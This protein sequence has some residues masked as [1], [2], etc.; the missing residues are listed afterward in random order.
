MQFTARKTD[1]LATLGR[2]LGAVDKR[3]ALPV[4]SH[5]LMTVFLRGAVDF[6]ACDLDIFAAS[7]CPATVPGAG[8]A[9][10]V[11]AERLRGA[12]QAIP[13]PEI[14]F[15]LE[16]DLQLAVQSGEFRLVLSCLPGDEFV[17]QT[18]ASGGA[19]A[20]FRPEVLPRLVKEVSHAMGQDVQKSTLCGVG[21]RYESGRLTAVA[22]DGHRLSLSGIDFPGLDGFYGYTFPA[23]LCKLLPAVNGSIE[24]YAAENTVQLNDP[25][26]N[27]SARL[28]E[29]E[30]P[31]YR[32]VIPTDHP[33]TLTVSI[34]DLV[35]AVEACGVVS[36]DRFR[37]VSLEAT[38]ESLSV[39]ALGT[40][41]TAR[42]TL[43]CAGGEGF[44]LSCNSRYLLQ[45]LESLRGEEVC[46]K[47]GPDS[48]PVLFIPLDH[49]G[50]DERL[51]LIMP[52]KG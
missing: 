6:T 24:M 29:G 41:G 30:F 26:T 27:L 31:S 37:T 1:L 7:E 14:E 4:L 51:E 39:S 16:E 44:R 2:V 34:G 47:Y 52:L 40:Q 49:S 33:G 23:K 9:V 38:D 32:R 46:I 20:C 17:A 36:E 48:A 43:P 42:V 11:P 13:G 22:T 15:T 21:L 10:C 25:H 18:E 28:L 50:W 8:G 12:I 3:S 5:V 45:A 19:I 35:A